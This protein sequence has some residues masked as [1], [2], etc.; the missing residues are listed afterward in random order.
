[1]RLRKLALVHRTKM[2]RFI[3]GRAL[4]LPY[5]CRP[6]MTSV[7]RNSDMFDFTTATELAIIGPYMITE[8]R[9]TFSLLVINEAN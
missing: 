5:V 8:L 1:M 2:A 6:R 4:Y 7:T 3:S 9:P